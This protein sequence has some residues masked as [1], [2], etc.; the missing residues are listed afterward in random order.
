MRRIVKNGWAPK[1]TALTGS[2]TGSL[3]GI[4]GF[5]CRLIFFD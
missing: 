2:S 1:P 5:T 3:P 4:D